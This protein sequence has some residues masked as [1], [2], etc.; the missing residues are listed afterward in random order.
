MTN[1]EPEQPTRSQRREER[2]RR[3]RRMRKTGLSVRTLM[4]IIRERAARLR[5]QKP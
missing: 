3:R 2:Q 4:Q 1:Q 5:R